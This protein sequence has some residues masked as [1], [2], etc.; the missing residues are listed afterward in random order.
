MT[1]SF[2]NRAVA[3][4][5]ERV[6]S[7]ITRNGPMPVSQYVNACLYDHDYGFYMRSGGGRAGGSR[8]DFLTAPEVGPL[9]GA[10][11]A[12]ALDAWWV[13][14]GKPSPFV[15]IDWGAGPG[16]L[17]RSVL[18]AKPLCMSAHALQWVAVELSAAQRKL[19]IDHPMVTS[20]ASVEDVLLQRA[21]C[22]IIIANELLDNLPFD[23]VQRTVGGWNEL[24]VVV[25]DETDTANPNEADKTGADKN[26]R[27]D[28]TGKSSQSTNNEPPAFSLVAVPAVDSLTT[29]L[30]ALS[31]VEVG[32]CLPVQNA[33][34]RW[35]AEAH[36]QLNSGRI[37]ALDFFGFASAAQQP[38]IEAHF[39]EHIEAVEAQAG[40]NSSSQYD[41]QMDGSIL[42]TNGQLASQYHT[43]R[44]P[45]FQAEEYTFSET[46]SEGS[47]SPPTLENSS[48]GLKWLRTHKQHSHAFS[49]LEKPGSC[50]ITANV[51]F[52]QIQIDHKAQQRQTMAD[53]LREHG[54]EELVAEGRRIWLERASLGDLEAMKARSRI[55]EAV[56]LLAPNGFGGFQVLT[57]IIND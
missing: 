25:T 17:T 41:S 56:A 12:K 23:I 29:N 53:F 36:R 15:V 19:H 9:F 43:S 1:D 13:D 34:R 11:I 40:F 42:P 16:T 8:G 21:E 26:S 44:K 57:W 54:I 46:A 14:L 35:V 50:D 7:E 38:S 30:P 47:D 20:V 22:G 49:W 6:A 45:V 3:A 31:D 37:V 52:H 4:L 2:D 32:T 55:G 5:T 39:K 24:R 51:D 33:A 10:V 28:E 18:D 48:A 27:A